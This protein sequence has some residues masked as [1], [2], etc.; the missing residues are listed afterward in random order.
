MRWLPLA[1]FICMIFFFFGLES[2]ALTIF[3][4]Q[5]SIIRVLFRLPDRYM[6]VACILLSGPANPL[7]G[8]P[9]MFWRCQKAIGPLLIRRYFS[10]SSFILGPLLNHEKHAGNWF[11]YYHY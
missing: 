10:L 8:L 3:A 2:T 5:F 4:G 11:V 1:I 9:A 7:L 6:Y